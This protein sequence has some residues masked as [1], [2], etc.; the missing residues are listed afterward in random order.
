M[1]SESPNCRKCGV[2]M[3]L[4]PSGDDR[5]TKHLTKEQ[6]ETMAT[7]G[8]KYSKLD[9]RRYTEPG[10]NKKYELVCFK[11]NHDEGKEELSKLPIEKHWEMSRAYPKDHP[12]AV[13]NELNKYEQKPNSDKNDEGCD[14]T[15]AK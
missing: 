11:C 8:H 12:M 14:T 2:L 5:A 1:F 10:S 6:H 3:W 4:P 15:E 13:K 9:E 7:I